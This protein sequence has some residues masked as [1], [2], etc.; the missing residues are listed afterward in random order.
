MPALNP[1]NQ[2]ILIEFLNKQ[3]ARGRTAVYMAVESNRPA[4][5]G[6]LL[7]YK[8][9]PNIADKDGLCPLRLA[10]NKGYPQC[11]DAL[12]ENDAKVD[13]SSDDIVKEVF[14]MSVSVDEKANILKKILIHG[15]VI[16]DAALTK[17][18]SE[19]KDNSALVEAVDSALA[20]RASK[21]SAL[22]VDTSKAL[23]FLPCIAGEG[24]TAAMDTLTKL[25]GFTVD[26]TK[27]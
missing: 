23:K 6:T 10:I 17:L 21:L 4:S 7:S 20:A 27:A 14:G 19:A 26:I 8:A 2:K 13:T 11:I 22:L 3:E 1:E 9:D 12:L 5:L 18:V 24:E 16:E 15:A 25:T